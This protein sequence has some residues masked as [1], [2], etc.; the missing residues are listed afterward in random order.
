[1]GIKWG[2]HVGDNHTVANVLKTA[3][4][5]K[6]RNKDVKILFYF[7][8]EISYSDCY[9]DFASEIQYHEDWWL[10]DDSG[11]VIW[12][13]K[14]KRMLLDYNVKAATNSWIKTVVDILKSS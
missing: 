9:E 12:N 5:L 7:N 13:M 4:D 3:N 11:N 8:V 2:Q 1:M 14:P 10:K 6:S